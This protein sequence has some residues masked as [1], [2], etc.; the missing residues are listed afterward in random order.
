MP[1]K[2]KISED[3]VREE[4]TRLGFADIS[5]DV[6]RTFRK[7]LLRLIKQD[8]KAFKAQQESG[9]EK[10]FSSSKSETTSSFSDSSPDTQKPSKEKL[11]IPKKYRTW[12][13]SE[14]SGYSD[15]DSSTSH[16]KTSDDSSSYAGQRS[17]R[18]DRPRE[19]QSESSTL[20]SSSTSGSTEK[21]V[22]LK[23]RPGIKQR[24][25]S[26]SRKKL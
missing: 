3:E 14:E 8:L 22:D 16:T 1:Y 10:S 13:S 20:T 6:V 26:A 7:D 2:L 9:E 21:S 15:Q 18:H 12:V 5:D 17:S 19:Q 23:R 11:K 25:R 4:L 24:P